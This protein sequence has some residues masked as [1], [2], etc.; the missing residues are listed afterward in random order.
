M[1]L[2]VFLLSRL[3]WTPWSTK[4]IVID[5]FGQI[6]VIKRKKEF[7]CEKMCFFQCNIELSFSKNFLFK[8]K[9]YHVFSFHV[10]IIFQQ[11]IKSLLLYNDNFKKT[12]KNTHTHTHTHTINI[13]VGFSS[14]FIDKVMQF[15][16]ESERAHC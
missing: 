16:S 5:F 4:L 14:S 3:Q 7:F 6:F 12:K 8:M 9:K 10:K 11:K 13:M 15:C 2:I 1:Q